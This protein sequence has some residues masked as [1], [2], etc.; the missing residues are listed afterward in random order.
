MAYEA[1][2]IIFSKIHNYF[3]VSG[4]FQSQFLKLLVVKLFL[5]PEWKSEILI[6]AIK[7][8]IHCLSINQNICIMMIYE[9]GFLT[10]PT[11]MQPDTIKNWDV[12]SFHRL[13][14]T[15]SSRL[16]KWILTLPCS[17]YYAFIF[18]V[19]IHS[20]LLLLKFSYIFPETQ[21]ISCLCFKQ[22]GFL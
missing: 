12:N 19:F 11:L 14:N 20:C 9:H 6:F 5:F 10:G 7:Y 22:R 8:L 2:R 21:W 4:D 17:F 1:L 18:V 3:V 13:I 16:F 15:L